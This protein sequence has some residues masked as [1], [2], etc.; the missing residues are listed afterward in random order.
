MYSDAG[1]RAGSWGASGSYSNRASGQAVS[2]E[3]VSYSSRSRRY[4]TSLI[5]RPFVL[6]LKLVE[7]RAGFQ[8][9]LIGKQAENMIG[10]QL[11]SSFGV[12]DKVDAGFALPLI[13]SPSFD[14]G[15]IHLF[16]ARDLSHLLGRSFQFAVRA[17]LIIPVSDA[18]LHWQDSD[19]LLAA[20]AP[21]RY[22]LSNS[23]ALKAEA[24]FGFVAGGGNAVM[25]FLN[26]GVL[27]QVNKELAIEGLVGFHLW[28]GS[29][30]S[31]LVPLKVRGTYTL[32]TNF[33]LVLDTGFLDLVDTKFDFYQVLI[34]AAYR[35]QI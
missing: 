11:G 5:D 26:S 33:D 1:R 27:V 23:L 15:E 18:N 7:T 28:L 22:H 16:A 10:M 31:T 20:N 29:E 9:D 30:N 2:P 21:I 3:A 17:N 34:G 8:M 35:F 4:P 25:T 12:M 13:V 32:M 19:F 24:W 14:L 6:P